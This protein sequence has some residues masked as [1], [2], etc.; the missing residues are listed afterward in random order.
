VTRVTSENDPG[1]G[2]TLWVDASAGV[3]GDMLLAALL[4]AG[5]DLRA[6]RAAVE[7]VLPGE[8]LLEVRATTRAGLRAQRLEVRLAGDRPPAERTWHD[9]RRLLEG[10][11]LPVRVRQHAVAVFTALA[12]A[13]AQVHGVAVEQ[14]HFHEVGA[15]DSIGDV[16]GVCAALD[17]LDVSSLHSSPLALGHGQVRAAHGVLPVPVPAVLELVRRAG[18]PLAPAPEAPGE[19]ATPTGVA[20]LAAL[21]TAHGP[22]PPGVATAVGV[23]AGT[24]DTPGRPNVTRVVLLRPSAVD[25]PEEQLSVMEC[26]VD[27]LD[28]RV[29]PEVIAG[30]LQLGVNDA[31]LAPVLMKKGRPGHV[32]TALVRPGLAEEAT[33]WLF[34]HTSTLGVR[35]HEVVRTALH[36]EHVTVDVPGGRVR[37]KLGRLGGRVVGATPEFEDCLALARHRRVPVAEVLADATAAA[38]ALAEVRER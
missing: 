38:R 20:V 22:M 10:A 16:V 13:E 33:A 11:A 32:L 35:R 37:V 7:A 18:L 36:R 4:D 8:L 31:W 1:T 9:V 12:E 3:A 34:R 5:A 28:P 15:W 17:A 27:D 30:L 23:G 25:S 19:A 6:V 2:A 21:A 14:V 29:W 26:T 24:R